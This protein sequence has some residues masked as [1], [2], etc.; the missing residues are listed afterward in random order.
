MLAWA[1]SGATRKADSKARPRVALAK[2]LPQPAANSLGDAQGVSS[3]ITAILSKRSGIY[4]G[5]SRRSIASPIHLE[6]I[7]PRQ[8]AVAN[9][10]V[11]EQVGEA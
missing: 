7:A 11:A 6:G 1:A 9:S 4:I 3:A 8:R 10:N 5:R 2:S